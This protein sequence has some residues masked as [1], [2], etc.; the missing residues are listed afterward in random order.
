MST[1]TDYAISVLNYFDKN[2]WH[3][4]HDAERNIIECGFNLKCKLSSTR[5]RIIFNDTSMVCR[6][7]VSMKAEP[8]V[9]PQVLEYISRAN[10]GLVYGNFEMDFDDGEIVYKMDILLGDTVPDEAQADILLDIP[11]NM[12]NRYGDGLL[13]VMFGMQTPEEAIQKAEADQN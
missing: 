12:I 6:S 8:S 7:A 5:M 3:Y 13:A 10:Y 1:A 9:R 2:N 11:I 4:T